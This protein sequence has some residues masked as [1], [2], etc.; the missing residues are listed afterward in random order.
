MKKILITTILALL[1]GYGLVNAENRWEVIS[2][3]VISTN[4]IISSQGTVINVPIEVS[5]IRID[6]MST[7]E[8]ITFD[9]GGTTVV[10]YYN[11]DD[12]IVTSTFDPYLVIRTS[13]SARSDQSTTPGFV[14][15]HYRRLLR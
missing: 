9:D 7:A 1:C 13:L 4:G 8:T 11:A 12:G 3:S 2:S 15:I 14:T 6:S 10:S 5:S